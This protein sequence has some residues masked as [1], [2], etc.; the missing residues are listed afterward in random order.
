MPASSNFSSE[1]RGMPLG[2]RFI[3]KE[4]IRY[5]NATASNVCKAIKMPYPTFHQ[6]LNDDS[7]NPRIMTLRIIAKHFKVTIDQLIGDTPIPFLSDDY[8]PEDQPSSNVKDDDFYP[9]ILVF[10]LN[11]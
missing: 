8:V 2:I 7:S 1:V 9:G 10:L 11:L 5:Q 3:L 4:L 6:I